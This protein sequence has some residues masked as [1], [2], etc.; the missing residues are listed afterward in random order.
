M[1]RRHFMKSA[2]TGSLTTMM[3]AHGEA[4]FAAGT[5]PVKEDPADPAWLHEAKALP[6]FEVIDTRSAQ[7][8][9]DLRPK[10][11]VMRDLI[12]AH[13]HACDGL[14]K[15]AYALR[16]LADFAFPGQPLD[17]TDLLV[18]TKNSPCLGDVAAYLTGGRV[19]FGSHRLDRDF[20]VQFVVQKIST[21]EAWEVREKPGIFPALYARWEQTLLTDPTLTGSTKANLLGVHEAEVWNWVR[22][23]LLTQNPADVYEVR[24]LA[25][26][27]LPPA[28]PA[29]PGVRTDVI[30]R[31]VAAPDD[32]LNPYDLHAVPPLELPEFNIW[33]RRYRVGPTAWQTVS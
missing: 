30:N 28:L 1:Q 22:N 24:K 2:T 13:G 7:G 18:V 17:R 21:G 6:T 25:R 10:R 3:A 12:M 4:S 19:R 29:E 20:G 14:V 11:V 8:R 5:A 15:G 16:A 32:F 23:T 31:L 9:L 26:V 33:V 27:E